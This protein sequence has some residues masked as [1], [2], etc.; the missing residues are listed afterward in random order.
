VRADGAG[1]PSGYL[2]RFHYDTLV[3]Y[4]PALAYLVGVVGADRV[5]LGSDHPFWMGDPEP[6]RVV[7]EAGLGADAERLVV[8][9]NAVRLF[10]LDGASRAGG[11]RP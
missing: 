8:G 6:L 3:Q 11:A 9:E 2:R 7:R 4:P 10:R 1:L 5:M